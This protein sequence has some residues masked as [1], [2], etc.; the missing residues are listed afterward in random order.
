MQFEADLI[1]MGLQQAEELKR[2]RKPCRAKEP[3]GKRNPLSQAAILTDIL[4]Y[5]FR[6]S[7]Q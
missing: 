2:E 5:V 3:R 4:G 7:R 1:A 6:K